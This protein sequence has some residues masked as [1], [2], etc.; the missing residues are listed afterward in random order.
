MKSERLKKLESELNDL[1]H[2]KKLG[3]VPKSD[4]EK[5]QMEIESIR[6]KINEEVQ[7]LNFLKESGDMEEYTSTKRS[8]AKP[9]FEPH[10]MPDLAGN[11]DNDYNETR[12]SAFEADS[13]T[14]FDIEERGVDDKSSEYD[15]DEDQFSDK[16][17]WNR[18]ARD[19][20][21][22]LDPDNDNW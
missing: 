21:M 13:S 10:S 12:E 4:E 18:A 8:T 2:W 7:R 14:L 5:H 22:I 1:E 16:K 11:D 17:R 20:D 9:A 6:S 3:L 19:K 15:D